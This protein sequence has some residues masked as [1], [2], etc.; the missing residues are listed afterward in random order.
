MKKL[1][2]IIDSVRLIWKD[3]TNIDSPQHFSKYILAI[4][5]K[6]YLAS[7]ARFGTPQYILDADSLASRAAFF[8]GTFKKNIPNSEFFY[9]MKCN[10]LPFIVKT[11]KNNGFNA[12]AAGLFELKL[13]LKLGFKKIIFTSPGKDDEEI[14]LALKHSSKIIMNIDNLDEISMIIEVM[15]EIKFRRR[16]KISFRVNPDT[17]I[18][19]AWSKYGMTL[20]QLP[21]A[22][23]KIRNDK[24]FRLSGLHFHTSWNRTP[25][26]QV[27]K[28]KILGKFLAENFRSETRRL[29]FMDIGGGFFPEDTAVLNKFSFKGDLVRLLEE[30]HADDDTLPN[31]QFKNHSFSVRT[32]DPLEKFSESIS[33]ALQKYIFP[34]NKKIKIFFEPGR[35][36]VT[37]STSILTKVIAEKNGSVIVDAGVNLTGDYRFEEF[38]FAP[39]INLSRPSLKPNKKTIYG[40]L[41]DPSDLWGYSY[42][43]DSIKKGDYLLILHQGAYT[44][45]MSWRF[46]KPIAKYIALTGNKIIVAKEAESFRDRYSKCIF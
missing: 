33:D 22:I 12:D 13:A 34:L 25:D 39:I 7:A 8:T 3:K 15:S 44:F 4:N 43:G 23:K 9:A 38:S 28:I 27:K 46:I 18:T 10:D 17:S 11:L 19:K 6:R 26:R 2:R 24:R 14:K 30:W 1:D 42:Y 21:K 16:L 20:K 29:E 32:V 37:H 5:N 45:S 36:M 35:F 41:C 31:I 40:A